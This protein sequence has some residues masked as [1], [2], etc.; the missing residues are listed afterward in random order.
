M[1][2]L[3]FQYLGADN[4]YHEGKNEFQDCKKALRFMYKFRF[5]F[6]NFEWICDDPEDNEYLYSR[7]E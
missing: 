2:T 6:K 7:W 1:I 4:N 5:K 3:T